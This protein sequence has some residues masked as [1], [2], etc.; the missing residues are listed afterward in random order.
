MHLLYLTALS[1]SDYEEEVLAAGAAGVQLCVRSVAGNIYLFK[2]V[3][4]EV[5]HSQSVALS[6]RQYKVPDLRYPECHRECL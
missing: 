5:Q 1:T 2:P 6:V 3:G 4:S